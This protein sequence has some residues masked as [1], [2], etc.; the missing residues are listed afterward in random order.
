MNGKK[1]LFLSELSE[2]VFSFVIFA[3]EPYDR[4]FFVC[5]WYF[6]SGLRFLLHL[7]HVLI[8]AIF[9]SQLSAFGLLCFKEFSCKSQGLFVVSTK[10]L[11]PL[12]SSRI[13]EN[14]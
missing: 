2:R 7:A 8:F 1:T 14:N 5:L 3:I 4:L 12:L 11:F 10:L 6:G 13:S 9:S